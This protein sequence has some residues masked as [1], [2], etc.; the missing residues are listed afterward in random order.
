M[1]I[2]IL[3]VAREQV[4]DRGVG[5]TV[6]QTNDVL[7]LPGERLPEALGWPTR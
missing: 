1:Q 6:E 2:D 5:L 4:L 3:E 7:E